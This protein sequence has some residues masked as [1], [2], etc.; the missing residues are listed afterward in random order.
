MIKKPAVRGNGMI[1][2]NPAA[3]KSLWR[4][5]PE[6]AIAIPPDCDRDGVCRLFRLLDV[7][8][9]ARTAF[10]PDLIKSLEKILVIPGPA[11]NVPGL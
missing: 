4:C 10:R 5:L 11:R 9:V 2:G 1:V 6:T 7:A 3:L 8:L